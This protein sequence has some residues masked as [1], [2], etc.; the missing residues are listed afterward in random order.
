[1]LII[2]HY[3][4]APPPPLSHLPRSPTTTIPYMQIAQELHVRITDL[5]ISEKLRD[6]RQA[7]LKSLIKVSGVVT[8][9]TSV[10]PQLLT[11]SYNCESCGQLLGPYAPELRLDSCPNC[12]GQ[13]FK[14]N[15]QKT[16]YGNFQRVTLQETPGSVPP[17]R[18]PR[19]KEVILLGDLIDVARPGEEVE[20]TGIYMHSQQ[21]LSRK[22]NGFPVFSTVIEA[23]SV[24]K[25]QGSAGTFLS[26]ED[27]RKIRDLG[28]DPQI[29]ERIIRSI[30]PS[31]YG[32]RHVKTGVALSLFGGCHKDGGSGGGMHRVRGDINLLLL[33]NNTQ[34]GTVDN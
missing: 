16:K 34:P 17:G 27:K 4:R 14:V 9:R 21:T 18:V 26:D 8:R 22:N 5:P 25:R 13:T 3:L 19:H 28:N 12:G 11:V 20:V 1:M 15:Q 24:Q 32:H 2:N 6:L 23:N 33:G 7:D 30:A 31:I 29:G 10:F